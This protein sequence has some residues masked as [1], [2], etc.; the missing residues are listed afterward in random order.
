MGDN[1]YKSFV[2]AEFVQRLLGFGRITA[3]IDFDGDG[4]IEIERGSRFPYAGED[5]DKFFQA[6]MT[7]IRGGG[8]SGYFAGDINDDGSLDMADVVLFRGFLD[9]YL[10]GLDRGEPV[11]TPL[12]LG[13]PWW[14]PVPTVR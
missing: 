3:P 8:G 10:D 1:D 9:D 2:T 13:D 6:A 7:T 5:W 12:D 14:V 11:I 4:F